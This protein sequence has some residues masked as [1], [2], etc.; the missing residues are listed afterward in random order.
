ME[1][2]V[3]GDALKVEQGVE[4]GAKE[5]SVVDVVGVVAVIAVD[6]C[7][8]QDGEHCGSGDGAAA[9]VGVDQGVSELRLS[10]SL[11]DVALCECAEVVAGL[12]GVW[13]AGQG[14]IGFGELLEQ[15]A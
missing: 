5:Q 15:S 7:G 14:L 11:R 10:S 8:F 4:V 13:I 3:D 6:V 9:V 1:I 2:F 12:V